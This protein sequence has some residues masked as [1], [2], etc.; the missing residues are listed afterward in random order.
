MGKARDVVA[1]YVV[2]DFCGD[3]ELGPDTRLVLGFYGR[4]VIGD[5]DAVMARLKINVVYRLPT[6][7]NTAKSESHDQRRQKGEYKYSHAVLR[8]LATYPSV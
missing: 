6:G 4:G 5:G 7:W 3:S 2:V 8:R 1:S